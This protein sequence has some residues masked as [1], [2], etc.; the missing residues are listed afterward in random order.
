MQ[1][2]V[3]NTRP[4]ADG[5]TI[6]ATIIDRDLNRLHLLD[7]PADIKIIGEDEDAN[8]IGQ[9]LLCHTFELS[10]FSNPPCNIICDAVLAQLRT[11]FPFTSYYIILH[12]IVNINIHKT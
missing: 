3:S 10:K 8:P 1:F 12:E 7:F 6:T 2:Y 5:E 11:S 4:S 9:F